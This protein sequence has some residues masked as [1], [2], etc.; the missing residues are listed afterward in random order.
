MLCRDDNRDSRKLVQLSRTRVLVRMTERRMEMPT[1]CR[2]A[3]RPQPP[4]FRQPPSQGGTIDTHERYNKDAVSAGSSRHTSLACNTRFTT[5]AGAR[6]YLYEGTVCRHDFA[7]GVC[8]QLRPGSM[9]P[10]VD[11]GCYA[12]WD[13]TNTSESAG[14]RKSEI[15]NQIM[16][17]QIWKGYIFKRVLIIIVQS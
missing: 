5:S 6:L 16:G 1:T 4:P 2:H 14:S 11:A 17:F 12:A 7:T 10:D 9:L 15:R 13:P 8:L 3:P